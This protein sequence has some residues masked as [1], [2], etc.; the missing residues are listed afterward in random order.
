MQANQIS[1]CQEDIL[2][3]QKENNNLK[4]ELKSTNRI[5]DIFM[6]KKIANF[7]LIKIINKY[8]DKLKIKIDG[9]K[10]KLYFVSDINNI[11]LN[12]LNKFIEVIQE[13][14]CF[15]EEKDMNNIV[16][17]FLNNNIRNNIEEVK[18]YEYIIEHLLTKEELND[19]ICLE[20]DNEI[21]RLINEIK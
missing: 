6:K 7:I 1:K 15:D 8:K 2:V 14:S 3:L 12:E 17:Y 5:S 13:N 9:K 16:N 18:G 11:K 10:N 21:K 19:F 20:E 4:N